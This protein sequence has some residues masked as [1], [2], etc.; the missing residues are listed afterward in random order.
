MQ[1]VRLGSHYSK[2]VP[3]TFQKYVSFYRTM[4]M[5]LHAVVTAELHPGTALLQYCKL[6]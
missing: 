2:S 6:W 3:V 4:A 5:R 1:E